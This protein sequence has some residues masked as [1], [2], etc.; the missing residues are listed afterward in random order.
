MAEELHYAH[1]IIGSISIIL[2]WGEGE[3][4]ATALPFSAGDIT[5]QEYADAVRRTVSCLPTVAV[6]TMSTVNRK[7]RDKGYSGNTMRVAVEGPVFEG[8]SF[9]EGA[10][11]WQCRAS[12]ICPFGLYA[13]AVMWAPLD[14][15]GCRKGDW[16]SETLTPAWGGAL[17]EPSFKG[18]ISQ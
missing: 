8:S 10:L 14:D 12:S 13:A 16:Q 4:V 7:P 11:H 1:G 6:V 15:N 3:L 5:L 2:S 17:Y 9:P 18:W